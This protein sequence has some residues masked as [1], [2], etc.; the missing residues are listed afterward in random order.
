MPNARQTHPAKLICISMEENI[1][2]LCNLM[3]NEA[4]F[5]LKER[6]NWGKSYLRSSLTCSGGYFIFK[7]LCWL[8]RYDRRYLSSLPYLVNSPGSVLSTVKSG[9][10]FYSIS[11]YIGIKIYHRF[12]PWS[13]PT[14]RWKVKLGIFQLNFRL[15]REVSQ[16]W[17]HLE[18][19]LSKNE[20]HLS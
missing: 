5:F 1:H 14:Y 11:F 16:F 7:R 17:D 9:H 6:L 3:P 4:R 13:S 2:R 15:R 18:N 12:D 20:K 19:R 10:I 8:S